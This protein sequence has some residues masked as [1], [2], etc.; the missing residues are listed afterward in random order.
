MKTLRFSDQMHDRRRPTGADVETSLAHFS[1]ITYLADP[2]V[3]RRHIHPRFELDLVE[4]DGDSHALLSVV[5]FL[6]F[7]FHF[8][9]LPWFKWTFGQTNYRMYVTDTETGE[10]VVWFLGTTLDSSSVV[11]PRYL[12]NLPWHRGRIRFDCE[13]ASWA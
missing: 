6:D 1:I 5:P 7:D 3:A 12:W 10:H 11:I 8:A 2:T 13:F 4:I 9:S